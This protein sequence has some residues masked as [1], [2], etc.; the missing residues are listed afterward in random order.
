MPKSPSEVP[1][2]QVAFD[3]FHLDI[4]R[5][6]LWRGKQEVP[7]RPKAWDVLCYLLERPGLL[8]T[9]DTL[10]HAIWPDTAVSDDT[11]TKVIGELRQILGDDPRAPRVIETVHGRGFRLV[12]EVRGLAGERGVPAAATPAA[13][14][15]TASRRGEAAAAFV[16]RQPELASLHECL[17][18]AAEGTRQLVF[19]TGEPGIG[20]TTLVE[21]FLR[22]ATLRDPAISILWGQCIQQHGQR[23]PY[24]PVLE[25]LEQVLGSPPGTTLIP[26][27]R[28]VA[29]CWYAQI[30]WLRSADEPPGWEVAMMNAAPQRMLR[31]I[32][33]FLDSMAARS[34]VIL[35]LEDLHW[36][37][38]ATTD[39]LSFL[40]ER[41]EPARLLIIGTYRPTEAIT[42]EHP[43]R[44]VKQVLRSHG[45]AIDL[46]LPYLSTADVRQ[47]LRHRFGDEAERLAPRIH[48][49]TDGNPFFVVAL[50][51]ELIRRGPATNSGRNWVTGAVAD[52]ADLAV[53]E[54]LLEMVTVQFQGLD[55]DERVVL[56]AGSVAGMTFAPWLVARALG[57]DVEEVE[58][59]AERMVR[60]HRFLI[61]GGGTE[62]RAAAR[63]YEFSHALHRQVIYEQVADTRRQ[64]LHQA[65]G[66]ALEA[67]YADR[68]AEIA[69][70][71]SVH[72]ERSHD[73][74][75]AV[76]YL[77]LCIAG[78]QQRLAHREAVGYGSTAL[79]LL[80]GMLEIPER[81][82]TELE[83][84]L[85]QGVSL[86]V[87]RGYRSA[88]VKE[89][90]MRARALCEKVG[91]ARQLF[92]IVHAVWY[93]QLAGTGDAEA[94]RSVEDLRRIAR[95]LNTL[96]YELRAELA[97]ART[98][99]WSGHV[100]TAVR[101]F[102]HI[103]ERIESHAVDFHAGAYGVHPMVAVLAQGAVALWLHGRPDQARAHAERGLAAAE[104]SAQPFDRASVLC[105]LA[106][107]EL[108]CGHT[109]AAAA[110]AARAAAIARD[111]DVAYFQPFSRFL[112]GAALAAQGDIEAGLPDMVRGLAEQRAIS[113][114]FLGDLILAFIASAHGRAGQWDEGLERV[115]EGL[116]MAETNLECVFAAELWRVKGELLLGKARQAKSGANALAP[117][118]AAA[119]EQCFRRALETAR[120][121]EA[122]SLALRAAMSL[123]RLSRARHEKPESVEPLRA[124]YA[125]FTEGFGTRDLTDAGALL[126]NEASNARRVL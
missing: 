78:A 16:G 111:Q 119:A 107:V 105:H 33:A 64:R 100:G 92:E 31:E 125:S 44:E 57:R 68:L 55:P 13:P 89:N 25:A 24:M 34:T 84:R 41:R 82:R 80:R 4:G 14:A 27:L 61:A 51:E 7:L 87:T 65:I 124:V 117:R 22:S 49:R 29:P 69:P 10:H 96:E 71:L 50:V 32:G 6:R 94:R 126:H 2:Q 47:Y 77:A 63:P 73:L 88:E 46:A 40:A 3:A 18:L 86:N 121:Q 56:E 102:T 21:E 42:Q 53:P 120:A 38:H 70:A 28:R 90:Y 48:E 110:T 85:L 83:L 45:H 20:K 66:Q 5:H 39:L 104:K 67:A 9:K 101:L 11:L 108:L 75:R 62:D 114:P 99:L 54:T 93:P 115:E 43:I 15:T 72:F 12:A 17:R 112:V 36:S 106:F 30:P 59:I 26:Q 97:W 81:N 122:G 23:E 98:E 103:L 52:R 79:G 35:V 109:D 58:A 37:D 91:D 60:S 19:I 113:G 116:A 8:V 76:K 74:A 118:A 1:G 95:Q 123:A